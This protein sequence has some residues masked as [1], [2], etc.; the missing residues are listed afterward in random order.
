[1]AV[2]ATNVALAYF[3]QQTF[4][5]TLGAQKGDRLQLLDLVA[6]VEVQHQRISLPTIDTRMRAKVLID[7][8][9]QIVA[10][11]SLA[12]PVSVDVPLP[13]SLIVSSSVATHAY[14][15]S[16]TPEATR[17]IAKRKGIERLDF[18]ASGAAAR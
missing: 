1:M 18:A 12:S 10:S 16:R 14:P 7:L 4:S 17:A 15:T 8:A 11:A 13:I 2:R 3:D 6:M 9:I 5:A